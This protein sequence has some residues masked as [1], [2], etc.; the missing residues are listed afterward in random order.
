M[1]D[2]DPT[3]FGA[4]QSQKW[5]ARL[6]SAAEEMGIDIPYFRQHEARA[7][8]RTVIDGRELINFASY[9]YLGLNQD[10][11]VGAAAINAIQNFGTSVSA[12]RLIA[13]ERAFHRALEQR[14]ANLH[15]AEAA[16]TLVSGHATNVTTIGHLLGP[17]DLLVYD[18]SIHNSAIMGGRLAR[19]TVHK[20]PHNNLDALESYLDA[21]RSAHR[22]CLIVVEGLYSMEGDVPDLRRLI[23]LKQRHKAWLMVDEAHAVGALGKTGR[24]AVEH[25]ELHGSEVDIWM[26][27]LSK[28][29]ASSGGYIAGSELLIDYMKHSAPGFVFSVG[30]APANA[31]AALA[32][33]ELM[34]Q[35]PERIARLREMTQRL[36]SGA[37]AIGFEAEHSAGAGIVPIFVGASTLAMLWA[38]LLY[39]DG[40]NVLP[41]IFP[42][43]SHDGAILR[44]FVSSA[45]T[46][47][48]IDLTLERLRPT[49][50]AAVSK[51]AE[52]ELEHREQRH[53]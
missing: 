26:G 19:P 42:A 11:R 51:I 32:A 23:E 7:G 6:R 20:F 46:S 5:H 45:H 25:F 50:E 30:L 37:A 21:N 52:L 16:L 17:R 36:R 22:R 34:Q 3:D 31:A 14:L 43:V 39:R 12:S 8:A 24:G 4:L 35:E 29:L 28:T 15:G 9:D 41:I 1:T 33:L 53:G 13:G 48:Q 38:E 40:I 18:A 2:F 49:Y 44:F 10:P 27:T 47:E